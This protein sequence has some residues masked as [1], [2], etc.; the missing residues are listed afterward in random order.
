MRSAKYVTDVA[1]GPDEL[2]GAFGFDGPM[3]EAGYAA[4]VLLAKHFGGPE[5]ELQAG[6]DICN[7]LVFKVQS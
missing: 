3:A 5:P 4:K 7:G 6:Y 1:L 2:P